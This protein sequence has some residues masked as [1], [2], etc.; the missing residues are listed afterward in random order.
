MEEC[1][2]CAGEL[3]GVVAEIEDLFETLDTLNRFRPA[4]IAA[5]M[6]SDSDTYVSFSTM[7]QVNVPVVCLCPLNPHFILHKKL[8]T[9][10]SH[11]LT[12]RPALRCAEADA[13]MAYRLNHR[14]RVSE[15]PLVQKECMDADVKKTEATAIPSSSSER[16]RATTVDHPPAPSD[17]AA[18][19]P[20]CRSC[21]L[22]SPVLPEGV[23][24][25]SSSQLPWKLHWLL[26]SWLDSP[27]AATQARVR[28][29]A[30]HLVLLEDAEAR[31]HEE[32]AAACHDG[33]RADD[34]A[35]RISES[36]RSAMYME[37]RRI[38][39]SLEEADHQRAAARAAL[40]ELQQRAAVAKWG[41]LLRTLSAEWSPW[42][43]EVRI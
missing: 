21:F 27:L 9:C 39:C 38:K 42:A 40:M 14:R 31:E 10:I 24:E 3:Q 13:Q 22:P 5:A 35:W 30:A 15:P 34:K 32:F 16:L 18:V 43:V 26:S 29:A 41:T 19:V 12:T 25:Q 28:E 36:V 17:S 4:L 7:L 23:D 2:F 33:Q 11:V 8:L 20:C 37:G 6:A 1:A